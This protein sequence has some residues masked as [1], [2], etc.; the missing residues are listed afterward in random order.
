MPSTPFM[1]VR[2]SWLMVARKRLLASFADSAA[3]LATRRS[4]SVWRSSSA[5]LA[6]SRLDAASCR[7]LRFG[8]GRAFGHASFQGLVETLEFGEV[9]G[10]LQGGTGDGGDEIGE[11]F[12]VGAEQIFDVL[13]GDAKA[14]NGTTSH[15]ERCAQRPNARR[16]GLPRRRPDR[17]YSS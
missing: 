10:V 16:R 13:V 2:I 1:G 5:I 11:S 17:S 15:E 3:C 14:C 4:S 12:F 8:G 7:A 6:N 9:L